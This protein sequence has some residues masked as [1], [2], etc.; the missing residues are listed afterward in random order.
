MVAASEE[1]G[2]GAGQVRK[3]H[4]QQSNPSIQ[5]GRS[6]CEPLPASCSERSRENGGHLIRA[7][8]GGV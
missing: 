6:G 2:D 3:H 1:E 8:Q 4:E 7:L 5:L